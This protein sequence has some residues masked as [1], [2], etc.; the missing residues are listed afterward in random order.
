MV[1]GTL[2]MLGVIIVSGLSVYEVILGLDVGCNHDCKDLSV[3]M[4]NFSV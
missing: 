2:E 4:S 1:E 3:K